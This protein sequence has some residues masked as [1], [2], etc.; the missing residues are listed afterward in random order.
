MISPPPFPA[1]FTGFIS[2]PTVILAGKQD[3]GSDLQKKKPRLRVTEAA[4][5]QWSGN[6]LTPHIQVSG[7]PWLLGSE[8]PTYIEWPHFLQLLI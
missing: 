1:I 8:W 3:R 6:N 2:F 4:R 7:H 5:K